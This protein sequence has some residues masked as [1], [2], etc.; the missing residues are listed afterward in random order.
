[1]SNNQKRSPIGMGLW[2]GGLALVAQYFPPYL[3]VTSVALLFVIFIYFTIKEIKSGNS[4]TPKFILV[5]VFVIFIVGTI[6]VLGMNYLEFNTSTIL[7]LVGII[8]GL[9]LMFIIYGITSKLKS[10]DREE[11]RIAKFLIVL[12]IILTIIALPIAYS[13]FTMI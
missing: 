6:F 9:T 13:I 10:G 8:G 1:M 7:K 2:M 11:I 12:L 5:L 4:R 3:Q